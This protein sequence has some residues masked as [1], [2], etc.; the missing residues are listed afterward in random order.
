MDLTELPPEV[1]EMSNLEDLS[2]AGN[3]IRELPEDMA[4]LRSLR[5][6]GLAGNLLS[7]LPRNIGN[8][9]EL[10]GLWVHGNQLTA[11]PDSLGRLHKLKQINLSGNMLTE[12]PPTIGDL[13]AV[14]ILGLA[15]NRL[16]NLPKGFGE[17]LHQLVSLQLHGNRLTSLPSSL[18]KNASVQSIAVQGNCLTS[19]PEGFGGQVMT[20]LSTINLA[21]N[22]LTSL[23][24]SLFMCPTLRVIVAYGN[25]IIR[26]PQEALTR[27]SLKQLWL[28]GN[29]LEPA[30]VRAL[31]ATG[32]SAVRLGLD[33]TQLGAVGKLEHPGGVPGLQVSTSLTGGGG[34]GSSGGSG[35]GEYHPAV[36]RKGYFKLVQTEPKGRRREQTGAKKVLVV[37][38]GS[39]PGEPNWAGLLKR[40]RA[41]MEKEEEEEEEEEEQQQQQKPSGSAS[42]SDG[43][44]APSTNSR[45]DQ[46]T[47]SS[48][49]VDFDVLY[50]VDAERKWYGGIDDTENVFRSR[51]EA[52]VEGYEGV[53]F[54]GDSMGATASLMFAD[55]ATHV[56]AFTPQIDLAISAIRPGSTPDGWERLR[57]KIEN[58]LGAATS[59]KGDS[60][61]NVR[62]FTGTW[63]H[64][65]T[66]AKVVATPSFPH[67]HLKVYGVDSH[68]L[69]FAMD[70]KDR[71]RPLVAQTIR[72]AAG[73]PAVPEGQL[74]GITPARKI[75]PSNLL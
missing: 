54:L 67:V 44:A 13:R 45:D 23:P 6:L 1:L 68:R 47:V 61:T 19:L 10:E 28:E 53:V 63:A 39:A 27:E 30:A 31:L 40:V 57:T 52:A 33:T 4:N 5:R 70:A 32:Q 49:G 12:L 66:Q 37:A 3:R 62:V 56:L 43:A 16:S 75:R 60:H 9:S 46:R 41:G 24:G 59:D 71:L 25:Q 22:D 69:A 29:P 36:L 8:L 34:G 14:E 17:E 20:S 21:D 48:Y 74:E 58:A 18:G 2:L 15:G 65:L 35:G 7:R 64:D 55:L 51:L 38:F 72:A 50:V 26:L 11:I 73:D 42:L